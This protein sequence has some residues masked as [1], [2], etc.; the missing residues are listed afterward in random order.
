MLIFI[1]PLRS[2]K[3]CSDW[4]SVSELCNSTLNSITQQTSP[5]FKVILCC[6]ERPLNFQPHEKVFVVE[7]DFP[8]PKA[9][10]LDDCNG[11]IYAKVKRCM[12]E[13][14][15]MGAIEPGSHTFIMKVDA[16]DLISNR[17]AKFVEEHQS[18]DGWIVERGYVYE[19]GTQ[20]VYIR[21][22]FDRVSGTSHIFKCEY[23]DFPDST[24]TPEEDWL[25]TVW[26]HL[27]VNE[28]LA[29]RGKKLLGVLPFPGA[30]YRISSQ[31]ISSS[32]LGDKRFSSLK[33]K[34]WKLLCKRKLT[35]SLISEFG[36]SE[37]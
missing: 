17:I 13:V 33:S 23:S 26:N 37:I 24:D 32:N 28:L 2:P 22:R 14:K 15:R 18:G 11:D 4:A 27:R 34:I 6:N 8:I 16:D 25:D 29:T 9:L 30:V 7:E 19:A 35:S 21:P 10:T 20:N 31:H 3:T 1:I 36:F 5:E 12:V